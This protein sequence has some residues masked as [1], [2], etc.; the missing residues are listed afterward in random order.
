[1]GLHSKLW[2]KLTSKLCNIRAAVSST[3][4]YKN[5]SVTISA[6]SL[7]SSFLMPLAFFLSFLLASIAVIASWLARGTSQASSKSVA[8]AF[9]L[10]VAIDFVDDAGP[11]LVGNVGGS[12]GS[13]LRNGRSRSSSVSSLCSSY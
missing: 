2:T 11:G 5:I 7:V 12:F 4:H 8:F 13:V 9:A 10:G 1:M 6:S 3:G